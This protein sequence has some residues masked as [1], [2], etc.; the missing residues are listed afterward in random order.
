[1]MHMTNEST[2]SR[3]KPIQENLFGSGDD[4]LRAPR[5]DSM[6]K[7]EAIRNR[8]ISLLEKAR[9]AQTMPWT[10]KDARMWRIVFPSM[11]NW[12]PKDEAEHLC[13]AFTKE[14]DRLEKNS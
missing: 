6:P 5:Q 11:A 4:R 10:E 3:R 1:M 9:L 14:M 12:L 7:P 8:L 13:S 2:I